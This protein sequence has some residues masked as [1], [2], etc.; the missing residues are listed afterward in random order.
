LVVVVYGLDPAFHA[1]ALA[2]MPMAAVLTAV[3]NEGF[4]GAAPGALAGGLG[5][6]EGVKDLSRWAFVHGITSN[7]GL[8]HPGHVESQGCG[9]DKNPG[10]EGECGFH[11]FSFKH[12]ACA[13][14][15]RKLA[16]LAS[17][18]CMST[19][20]DSTRTARSTTKAIHPCRMQP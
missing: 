9:C 10:D 2:H 16:A 18:V 20:P 8:M 6:F 15:S 3:W 17:S 5:G 11:G 13:S 4:V 7:K 12:W 19:H 14:A 1:V